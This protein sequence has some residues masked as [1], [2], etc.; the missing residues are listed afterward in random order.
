MVCRRAIVLG[1]FCMVLCGARSVSATALYT[2]TDLGALGMG[3]ADDI[4]ASGQVVGSCSLMPHACLYSDGK[5]TDL[6]TLSGYQSS[7]ATGINASGQV[8]GYCFSSGNSESRAFIYSN[9]TMTDLNSLVPGGTMYDATLINDN[10]WIVGSGKNAS[11]QVSNFLCSNGTMT[12]LGPSSLDDINASG[13]MVGVVRPVW[14]A[15]LYSNGTMI[16]LGTLPGVSGSG[17]SRALGINASG[18]VVGWSDT[19]IP[20]MGGFRHAFLYNGGTMKDMNNLID[21]STGWTLEEAHAIS[22]SGQIVGQGQTS[23]FAHGTFLL[24]PVPEP[25]TLVLLGVGGIGLLAYVWR[26]RSAA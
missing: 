21:L 6:G 15:G 7:Y 9:G 19:Y 26:R 14:H 22:D 2:V 13:Q 23:L 12:D 25:S 11:G 1:V 17:D 5:V 4:N 24:T 8:V 18:D 10:G 3:E 16:D 20:G